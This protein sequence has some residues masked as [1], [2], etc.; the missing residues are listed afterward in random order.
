M[1]DY[2]KEFELK[3]NV[4]FEIRGKGIFKNDI[5][6]IISNFYL[7]FLCLDI[8]ESGVIIF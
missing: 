6:L 8:L 5:L 4:M 7:K 2:D 3:K 1:S